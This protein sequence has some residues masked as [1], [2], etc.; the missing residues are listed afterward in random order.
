[1]SMESRRAFGFGHAV[2][3]YHALGRVDA[4]FVGLLWHTGPVKVESGDARPF[5]LVIEHVK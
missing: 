3:E 4:G 1:M 5:N 2:P